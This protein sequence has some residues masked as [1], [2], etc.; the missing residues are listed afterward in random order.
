MGSMGDSVNGWNSSVSSEE[1]PLLVSSLHGFHPHLKRIP[2]LMVHDASP[3]GRGKLGRAPK[4]DM[5]SKDRNGTRTDVDEP[6]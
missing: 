3:T 5:S 4:D 1:E 6:A 2:E